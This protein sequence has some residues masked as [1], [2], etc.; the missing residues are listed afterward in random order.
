MTLVSRFLLAALCV[1]LPPLA[2]ADDPPSTEPMAILGAAKAASGGSAWNDLRAQHSKV[3][4][5]TGGL[6]GPVERWSEFLTGR[7]YLTYSIGPTSGA[8]GF[9]GKTGWTQ[10]ASGE[11]RTESS[12]A[13]RELAVNA[14]FRDQLGFWFPTRHPAKIVFKDREHRDDADFDVISITPEGGREFDLWVNAGTH[15]IERLSE[16]EAVETRTEYYMDFR[17]VDGVRIPFRVR[18][19]RGDPRF[20]EVITIDSIDFNPPQKPIDFARPAPPKPDYTFPAGKSEVEIPFTLANGHIYVDVKLAGK[21]PFQMLLDAGG[22]NVLFPQTAATLGLAAQGTAGGDAKQDANVARVPSLD[23]G[24][25][26]LASQAFVTLPLDAQF[27]RIEGVDNVAGIVGYELFKRF[28]TRI[29][30]A[31]RKIVF[32]APSQWTYRGDGVKV[33]IRLNAQIPQVDGSIDGLPGVFDIDTGS[34]SSLTIASP[35]AV[36]N[37]LAGKYHASAEVIT[38]AGAGG[39]ARARLARGG[40]LKLGAV[41]VPQPVTLLSTATSGPLA[42]PTL[43]GDV[44]YGVLHRFN[45]VFDYRNEVMW[46]EKNV[47]FGT[48][49][50]HDRAGMWVERGN[51]GFAVVDVLAGGPAAQAGL[52]AGDVVQAVD[53]KPAA[54]VTLDEL[55]TRLKAATGSKVRLTLVNGHVVVVTL[56]D[57]V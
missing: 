51:K 41:D 47:A 45:L 44:G 56:R 17:D 23:V 18:A 19:T 34:R 14:A 43:A 54:H 8:A 25:I 22:S 49:D 26:V 53:G 2:F 42:D 37:D 29:D 11:S 16:Q 33:P 20:D 1:T 21:G 7:S 24:G 36:T 12:N 9:D 13:A 35:F 40:M 3:T 38:G 10:D 46:F 28:P 55:R 39:P 57:L 4:L 31:Q 52:K 5:S 15:L 27:R 30:Y 48:K 6:T 32:H 50:V